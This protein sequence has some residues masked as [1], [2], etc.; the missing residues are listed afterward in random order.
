VGITVT[1]LH[2]LKSSS[3]HLKLG[4]LNLLSTFI[5]CLKS[6]PCLFGG[7]YM[8]NPMKLISRNTTKNSIN[9]FA[10]GVCQSKSSLILFGF[11]C[12][13]SYPTI[14]DGIPHCIIN[15]TNKSTHMYFPKS[16]VTPIKVGRCIKRLRS[17][18]PT[19]G[20]GSH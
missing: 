1:H 17:I 16:I 20:L 11:G 14:F 8:Q 9:S 4:V 19:Q 7:L 6:G 15:R 5:G 13:A 18:R 12:C 10:I 3:E 2:F